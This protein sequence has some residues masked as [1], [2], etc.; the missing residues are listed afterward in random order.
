MFGIITD[1]WGI[2][3]KDFEVDSKR[4]TVIIKCIC[5]LHNLI[6]MKYGNNDK[7]QMVLTITM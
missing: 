1:K 4:A 5:I 6:S 2:V 7:D 3:G